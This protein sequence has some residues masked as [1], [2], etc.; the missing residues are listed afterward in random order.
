[1]PMDYFIGYTMQDKIALLRGLSEA[2]MTGQI[3]RVK[4]SRDS[5]TEFDPEN[6][7]SLTYQRLCDSIMD[8]PKFDQTD[9]TQLAVLNNRRVPITRSLFNASRR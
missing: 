8:D 9:P 7:S 6:D 3:I 5:E 4:T 2:L 1:M